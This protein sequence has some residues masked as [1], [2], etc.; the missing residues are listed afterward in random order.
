MWKQPQNDHFVEE[1]YLAGEKAPPGL[2]KQIGAPCVIRLG[3]SEALP[4]GNGG[5]AVCYRRVHPHPAPKPAP[6][7]PPAD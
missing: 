4:V 3:E 6:L 7:A 2:Y 5:H 1:L